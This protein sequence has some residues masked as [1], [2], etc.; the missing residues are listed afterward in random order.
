LD[1]E[2]ALAEDVA[3]LIYTMKKK[4]QVAGP[5]EG[6][7]VPEPTTQT[8]AYAKVRLLSSLAVEIVY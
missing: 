1:R 8:Q 4:G 3:S 5:R 6:R 7:L 2:A